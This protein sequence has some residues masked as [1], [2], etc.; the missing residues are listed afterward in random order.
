MDIMHRVKT[1][2]ILF[3]G[4]NV[5]DLAAQYLHEKGIKIWR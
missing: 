4:P 3:S 1:M 2:K 5:A